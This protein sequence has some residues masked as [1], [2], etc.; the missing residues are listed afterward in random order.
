MEAG[1]QDTEDSAQD[2]RLAQ[3]AKLA[4]LRQTWKW[5]SPRLSFVLVLK[6]HKDNAFQIA[7]AAQPAVPKP[8]PSI[9]SGGGGGG[10]CHM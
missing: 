3:W 6:L 1:P 2:V 4:H 5:P 10:G 9:K 7:S 8:Q